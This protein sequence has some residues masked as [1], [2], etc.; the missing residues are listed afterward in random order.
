M[1]IAVA[2]FGFAG[3]YISDGVAAA[4]I[5]VVCLGG[6]IAMYAYSYLLFIGKIR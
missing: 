6:C 1:G 4:A 3:P 5:S 2:A